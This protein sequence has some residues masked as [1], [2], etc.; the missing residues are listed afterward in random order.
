MPINTVGLSFLFC[1]IFFLAKHQ[2]V[3]DS[4]FLSFARL[5]HVHYFFM[6]DSS[7]SYATFDHH[8]GAGDHA[9]APSP[10]VVS[11][12]MTSQLEP[13][14][15]SVSRAR[16]L[17]AHALGDDAA[18]AGAGAGPRGHDD[19]QGNAQQGLREG[20]DDG[21][22]DGAP[23]RGDDGDAPRGRGG[24]VGAQSVRVTVSE[25]ASA[26]QSQARSAAREMPSVDR[27]QVKS[28]RDVDG[29]HDDTGRWVGTG[30]SPG[31]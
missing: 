6:Y 7:A 28:S 25:S 14:R 4:L 12:Q 26:L 23:A 24:G 27:A 11:P 1:F 3:R 29:A 22:V 15:R 5:T 30:C 13:L 21:S 19:A 16:E 8:G 10:H 9:H 2:G 31:C 18:G 20:R 17:F